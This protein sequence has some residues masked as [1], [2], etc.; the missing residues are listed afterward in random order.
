MRWRKR[1]DDWYKKV[2]AIQKVYPNVGKSEAAE[3]KFHL[4]Q[5]TY[6]QFISMRIPAN[7]SRQ[8]RVIN[9]KLA[10]LKDLNKRLAEV[11]VY[12]D[13]DYVVRSVTL[14]GE[15]N[16]HFAEAVM[17][18][19][20]PKGLTK[21][22]QKEYKDAVDQKLAALPRNTAIENYKLA[23]KRSSDLKTYNDAVKKAF[24][25]LSV[26]QPD[27]YFRMKEVPIKVV[28]LDL[29]QLKLT[30]G[31]EEDNKKYAPFITAIQNEEEADVVREAAKN[32]C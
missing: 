2:V 22:Q 21:Q 32:S 6:R 26:M 7:E 10:L 14:I 27:T 13:P 25:R 11:I 28:K 18:A 4:L 24:E 9:Q 1:A 30:E 23:I 8:A 3:A 19:P 31:N 16:E 15:A 12:D 29:F 20:L 17:T 5:E